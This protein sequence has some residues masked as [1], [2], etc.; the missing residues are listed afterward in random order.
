MPT[1]IVVI[2][3]DKAGGMAIFSRHMD[4]LFKNAPVHRPPPV[5][6]RYELFNERVLAD[7]L[8]RIRCAFGVKYYQA[9]STDEQPGRPLGTPR[10]PHVIQSGP[11]PGPSALPGQ[12]ARSPQ[13]PAR[14]SP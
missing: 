10:Y 13:P 1:K 9:S 11:H 3:G 6:E 4:R 5:G 7:D 14:A 8:A 12:G 2:I